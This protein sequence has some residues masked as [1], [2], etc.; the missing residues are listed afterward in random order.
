VQL[1]IAEK[2]YAPTPTRD[3]KPAAWD[4]VGTDEYCTEGSIFH[5]EG[6]SPEGNYASQHFCQ[7][8]CADDEDCKFYLYRH[9]PNAKSSTQYTCA[10]FKACASKHTFADGDGGHIYQKPAECTSGYSTAWVTEWNAGNLG[11]IVLSWYA[12]TEFRPVNTLNP[13]K[14]VAYKSHANCESAC[15]QDAASFY[16]VLPGEYCRCYSTKP[17]LAD[18]GAQP[19][20]FCSI[21]HNLNPT[22]IVG[23]AGESCGKSCGDIG[24]TCDSNV[25]TNSISQ[26]KDRLN[27]AGE[28]APKISQGSWKTGGGLNPAYLRGETNEWVLGKNAPD[29]DSA[30]NQRSGLCHCT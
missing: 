19:W 21:S 5:Q 27:K 8:A 7:N 11:G 1:Y 17:S 6:S 23:G 2:P 22:W 16:N 13:L 26:L 3:Q 15:N 4:I 30:G 24:K 20:E 28:S 9:D 10:T 29:C 12:M 18:P 14:S 25:R